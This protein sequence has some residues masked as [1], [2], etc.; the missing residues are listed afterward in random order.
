MGGQR[1]AAA[2]AGRH[3]GPDLRVG[4][5]PNHRSGEVTE[6]ATVSAERVTAALRRCAALSTAQVHDVAIESVRDTI[7]SRITRLRLTYQSADTGAPATLIL[8]TGLPKWRSSRWVGGHQE[9]AFYRDIAEAMTRHLAPRCFEAQWNPETKDWSLLLEDLTDT[10]MLPTAWPLPPSHSQ[11]ERIVDAWARFHA[12]WW[13][14]SRL[15][16]TIGAF[17]DAAA[18]DRMMQELARHFASFAD[19]LPKDRQNLYERLFANAARLQRRYAGRRNLT[20]VHGDAHVWNCFMPRHGGDD[21]RL[22]D[23]DA[24]RIGIGTTDL[25][26]MMAMHWYPD[27]RQRLERQLLDRYHASLLAEGVTG[28]DRQALEEDYRWAVVWQITTPVWQA[29]YGVPPVIW[30]NNMEHVLLAFD[31]LGCRDLLI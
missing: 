25:A 27:R 14:D 19:A 9:V 16:T 10:H 3:G 7:F 20:I 6:P 17:R 15:G 2:G 4:E 28:Y 31:D 21:V 8:K 5:V 1:T 18:T 26:N 23:W 29:A 13:D 11:C 12:G 22:F 30:W 24:W